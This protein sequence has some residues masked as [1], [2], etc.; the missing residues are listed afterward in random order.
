MLVEYDHL[1]KDEPVWIDRAAQFARK[2]VDIS[3]ISSKTQLPFTH[4]KQ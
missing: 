2:N 3:V 4:E 1:L